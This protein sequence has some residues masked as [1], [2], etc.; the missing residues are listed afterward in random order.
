LAC[1]L[2]DEGAD[3]RGGREAQAARRRETLFRLLAAA[4]PP[5]LQSLLQ[6]ACHSG[7]S[8]CPCVR[9]CVRCSC[10]CSLACVHERASESFVG[11]C[12]RARAGGKKS[13]SFSPP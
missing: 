2:G 6:S 11:F 4:L 3:A 9:T 1:L 13:L 7:V 10:V 8:G 12:E 5:H